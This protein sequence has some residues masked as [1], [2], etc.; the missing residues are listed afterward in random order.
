MLGAMGAEPSVTE[1]L[2]ELAGGDGTVY[3]RV[4]TVVYQQLR[5]IARS[6]LVRERAG[7]TVSPTVLVHEAYLKLVDQTGAT[8]SSRA[9]FLSVAALAMRRILV[10]H[11]VARRAAKRGGGERVL[12]FDEQVGEGAGSASFDELLAVDGL[13]GRLAEEHARPAQVVVH[14]IF[15]GLTDAE[16]AEV[17]EVSVPT[18][19]RDW[20]FARAWLTRE[21]GR[22]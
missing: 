6:Q 13:L 21:L 5:G 12:T 14:R 11:A 19:R 16:S 22:G 4:F 9:H 2:G 1:L 20:R 7:H 18:V 15:G 3:D 10:D 17:L 8:F